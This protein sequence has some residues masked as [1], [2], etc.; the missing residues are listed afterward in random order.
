MIENVSLTTRTISD[1]L[2]IQGH[3]PFAAKTQSSTVG[4][5]HFIQWKQG[6]S[7]HVAKAQSSTVGKDHFIQWKQGHSQHTQASIEV[8]NQSSLPLRTRLSKDTVIH[9][10][11]DPG[12]H[13][14]QDQSSLPPWTRLSMDTVINCNQD[15]GIHRSQEPVITAATDPIIHGHLH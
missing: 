4:K 13:R 6:H 11:Q 12:I 15:P 7:Q 10:N 9:C 5:D 3:N 2:W 14:S 1:L 8:K